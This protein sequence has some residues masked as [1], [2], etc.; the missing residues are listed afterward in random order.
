MFL[1]GRVSGSHGRMVCF[2]QRCF[3]ARF[4]NDMYRSIRPDAAGLGRQEASFV[5]AELPRRQQHSRIQAISVIEAS[6]R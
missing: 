1:I 2:H 3:V 5:E 4:A 6:M